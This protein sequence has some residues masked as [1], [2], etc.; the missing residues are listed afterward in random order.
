MSTPT[1]TSTVKTTQPIPTAENVKVQVAGTRSSKIELKPFKSSYTNQPIPLEGSTRRMYIR[2]HFGGIPNYDKAFGMTAS[3]FKKAYPELRHW[4]KTITEDGEALTVYN[5]AEFENQ[6]LVLPTKGLILDQNKDLDRFWVSQLH[7]EEMLVAN[8]AA[9]TNKSVYYIVDAEADA[10]V[11]VTKADKIKKCFEVLDALSPTEQREYGI[12]FGAD[13]INNS[14]TAIKARIYQEIL[15]K[16][17]SAYKWFNSPV[18]ARHEIDFN[19]AIVY[20][21]IR[22]YQGYYKWSDL[23]LG[24]SRDEA[25]RWFMSSDNSSLRM[26]IKQSIEEKQKVAS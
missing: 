19:L 12:L 22:L 2:T 6:Y 9:K 10:E 8:Q 11:I 23:V 18:E 15:E 13:P 14:S 16:P 3:A 7:R 5:P 26:K 25:K 17:D 24:V 1:T 20:G 21:I 4:T